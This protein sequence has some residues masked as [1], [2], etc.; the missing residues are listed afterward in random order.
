MKLPRALNKEILKYMLTS[1]HP[2]C[3]A[4]VVVRSFASKAI[5]ASQFSGVPFGV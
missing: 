3:L 5:C 1:E 4:E 2:P